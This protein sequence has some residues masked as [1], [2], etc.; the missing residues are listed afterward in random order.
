[1][2]P[3]EIVVRKARPEEYEA[4][5]GLT[6]AAYTALSGNTMSGGYEAELR[7]VAG[8]AEAAVVLVAV[9]VDT[10]V[11]A[12]AYIPDEHS[13]WGEGVRPGE[14]SIRML[15]VAPEAQGRGAGE[16]LARACLDRARAAGKAR[17]VLHSTPWMTSAHRLY[18]RLGFRRAPDRDWL[19]V[20]DVPLWAFELPLET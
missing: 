6:V 20:P 5:A 13:S 18:E 15:A 12:V 17:V 19:P 4:V 8:R 10:L 11:G 3:V 9:Q 14:A 7:D 2:K 16:A 1:M